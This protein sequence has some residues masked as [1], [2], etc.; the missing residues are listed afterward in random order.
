MKE[1]NLNQKRIVIYYL[2]LSS[3]FFLLLILLNF[4]PSSSNIAKEIDRI[5]ITFIFSIICIFGFSLDIEPDFA[6]YTAL[7]P[8]PGTIYHKIALK[9]GWIE[10]K[11]YA[12]Y[13]MAHAIMPTEKLTRKEVQMEL[14]RCYQNFYGSYARNLAG[15]FS[16]N[17]LKRTLYRHMAGQHVL[18]K[19]RRLI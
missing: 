1:I 3:I 5:I 17:K 6:I 18:S 9:N 11:N 10:D 15:I 12:N 14:L 2:S 8:F 16:K 4:L 19:F 7:T 13:D